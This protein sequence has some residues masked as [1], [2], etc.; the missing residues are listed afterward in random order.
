MS[1]DVLPARFLV[2]FAEHIPLGRISEMAG[3]LAARGDVEQLEGR[4]RFAVTVSR[5]SRLK[6]L[7]TE[8]KIWEA[9]G[10]IR[11]KNI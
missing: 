10:F 4:G 1:T 7:T 3:T 5:A 11:Y 6:S 8:F 9:H 2:E